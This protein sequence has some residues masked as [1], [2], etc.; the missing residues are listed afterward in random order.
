MSRGRQL[1]G[2]PFVRD[3]RA[4]KR[5]MKDGFQHVL[6]NLHDPGDQSL[7]FLCKRAF[8]VLLDETAEDVAM[9]E[10]VEVDAS[11][12]AQL[13]SYLVA[14]L[15]AQKIGHASL[16]LGGESLA[17]FLGASRHVHLARVARIHCHAQLIELDAGG[18]DSLAKESLL[19]LVAHRAWRHLA[20]GPPH[21][22][23]VVTDLVRHSREVLADD[24]PLNSDQPLGE[25]LHTPLIGAE[26]GK[27]R[28]GRKERA[29]CESA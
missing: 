3:R 16:H 29:L 1:I 21:V 22:L 9:D 20:D 7:R 17:L 28:M 26:A 11:R 25:G 18:T 14:Q 13:I 10:V 19:L 8:K 24:P 4:P 2:Q 15:V 6:H 23:K 5:L 12:L 27:L